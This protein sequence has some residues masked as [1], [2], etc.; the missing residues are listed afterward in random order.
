[1]PEPEA[2]PGNQVHKDTHPNGVPAPVDDLTTD[3]QVE[4]STSVEN[5]FCQPAIAGNIDR[6]VSSKTTNRHEVELLERGV[7][8][9]GLSHPTDQLLVQL[10][11]VLLGTSNCCFRISLEL[12]PGRMSRS[13]SPNIA[14]LGCRSLELNNSAVFDAFLDKPRNMRNRY[15]RVKGQSVNL[16]DTFV[17]LVSHSDNPIDNS[18]WKFGLN[19]LH[20]PSTRDRRF[21]ECKSVPE[22]NSG[23]VS[24][25]QIHFRS[26][27]GG[28][29]LNLDLGNARLTRRLPSEKFESPAMA[30]FELRSCGGWCQSS[31]AKSQEKDPYPC[32]YQ[33][34]FLANF[35]HDTEAQ[36]SKLANGDVSVTRG[37]MTLALSTDSLACFLG[38]VNLRGP[39]SYQNVAPKIILTTEL[40]SCVLRTGLA[41]SQIDE[42]RL[43]SARELVAINQI[44]KHNST[45]YTQ[46]DCDIPRHKLREETAGE[47]MR[48]ITIANGTLPA[49]R[50]VQ[51]DEFGPFHGETLDQNLSVGFSVLVIT[52]T[53]TN[54]VIVWIIDNSEVNSILRAIYQHSYVY[55]FPTVTYVGWTDQVR[56]VDY[57]FNSITT[58]SQL[59]ATI[60]TTQVWEAIR[61]WVVDRRIFLDCAS[62]RNTRHMRDII[63]SLYRLSPT[64]VYLDK[65]VTS[66]KLRAEFENLDPA[67][68]EGMSGYNWQDHIDKI[69]FPGSV[70]CSYHRAPTQDPQIGDF[71]WFVHMERTRYPMPI[72]D[73][74]HRH[75]IWRTGRIFAIEDHQWM[76]EPLYHVSYLCTTGRGYKR[77]TQW[78]VSRC[79]IARPLGALV[80][81]AHAEEISS[82]PAR[83]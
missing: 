15:S 55:G 33:S 51:I 24:R 25:L 47:P 13:T 32:R 63:S 9:H 30:V 64:E 6:C 62:R 5:K 2:Y 29:L 75:A 68:R 37:K 16:A 79:T 52:C 39:A 26:T 83:W 40:N 42:A 70:N 3:D 54:A 74:V 41:R 66:S 43:S 21:N 82:L 38:P 28:A 73:A 20:G 49:F 45:L 1:M 8:Q 14:T 69:P 81:V 77:P 46:G 11:V 23:E 67:D 71:V 48:N 36:Y 10:D 34:K 56:V 35:T 19:G 4:V 57:E 7:I 80:L 65:V 22:L 72:A 58:R 61:L 44:I 27:Q 59:R 18:A 76:V 12:G 50:A 17:A 53:T 60:K 31:H 78:T